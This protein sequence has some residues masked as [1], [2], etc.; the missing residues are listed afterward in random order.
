MDFSAEIEKNR[1][2]VKK[3]VEDNVVETWS[4]SLRSFQLGKAKKTPFLT[5][6]DTR[7]QLFLWYS[8][9]S[10]VLIVFSKNTN[11]KCVLDT[12]Y[13]AVNRLV[14]LTEETVSVSLSRK[15]LDIQWKGYIDNPMDLQISD[16][17]LVVGSRASKSFDKP[18][19]NIEGTNINREHT[20]TF[21]FDLQN[22]I[23][24]STQVHSRIEIQ[25]KVNGNIIHLPLKREL[26]SAEE[27]KYSHVPVTSFYYDKH[28]VQLRTSAAG[29]YYFTCR[30]MEVI[31]YNKIFRFWES[32]FIS[33][34]LYHAGFFIKKHSSRK[35]AL[36]FEKFSSKV[37]EGCFEIFQEALKNNKNN[38]YFI[39]D[40]EAPDYERIKNIP[41]VV[42]KYSPKY[43]WLL[44]RTN[45]YISTETPF[46]V[47]VL[48]SNNRYFRKT[49]AENKLIF[50]QHGV[51][52]LKYHGKNS[53][54]VRGRETS[55]S[56][57]IVNSEKEKKV[58]AK[59]LGLDSAQ[60]LK[61]G[62]PIFSKID[63]NHLS[64]R[65]KDIVVVM[66]T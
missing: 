66:L 56:Y 61:T 20:R 13:G 25:L 9:H 55:P 19:S 50:L 42:K 17:E 27:L 60:I 21:H 32:P 5:D 24:S 37:E 58:V 53:P 46:H 18:S 1:I 8:Y 14:D 15:G 54:L 22:L 52:Y 38:V 59:M 6:K 40:R 23:D 45:T 35:V 62:M 2:V 3:I 41:N 7:N 29:I 44:F 31:E 65:S 48:R 28:A 4:R 36:F 47:N 39:I 57:I 11:I 34:I 49:I 30:P 64:A 33:G 43:Y 10:K 26:S 63:Y 12:E 16:A 51:T